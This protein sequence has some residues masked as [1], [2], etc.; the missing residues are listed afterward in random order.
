MQFVLPIAFYEDA[1]AALIDRG[2][3]L[4]EE[5]KDRRAVRLALEDLFNDWALRGQ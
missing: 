4:E 5:V 3:L 1:I 2:E